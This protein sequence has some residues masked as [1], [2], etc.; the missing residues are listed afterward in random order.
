MRFHTHPQM[1]FTTFWDSCW[2][3]SPRRCRT[4]GN[5]QIQDGCPS[6]LTRTVLRKKK[7]H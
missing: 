6:A 2:F 5:N 1:T 7:E 3:K 4:N